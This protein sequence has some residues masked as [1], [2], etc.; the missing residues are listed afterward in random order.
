MSNLCERWDDEK[1]QHWEAQLSFGQSQ[2]AGEFWFIYFYI[3]L[4]GLTGRK[5]TESFQQK[6]Q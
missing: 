3:V 4:A 1:L 2:A 6:L 5:M